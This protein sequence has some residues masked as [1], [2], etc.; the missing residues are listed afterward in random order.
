[1]GCLRLSF[2]VIVLAVGAGLYFRSTE[3]ARVK[4]ILNTVL[5]LTPKPIVDLFQSARDDSHNAKKQEKVTDNEVKSTNRIFSKQDLWDN[6]RGGDES[7]GLYLAFF[8]KVFDVSK[9]K[10]HY[11][12]GG[13]YHFFAGRDGTKGFVTG[14]FSDEGLTDDIE[15]MDSKLMIGF[16]DWI[17]FYSSSYTYV[18]TVIGQFYDENGEPTEALKN[19]NKLIA[20]A[21][22]AKKQEDEENK[23]LPMC[24][25]ESSAAKGSR[26]WC[27]TKSGGVER[28]WVGVPRQYHPPGATSP[29]CACVRTAGKP[30]YGTDDG[31]NRGD[32]DN[33]YLREYNG[34]HSTSDSCV[35]KQ[36]K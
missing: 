7:K 35:I 15:G 8:G 10:E 36:P 29:R 5:K 28:N 12:P 31:K 23:I 26:V 30:S 33:P 4:E 3:D 20:E 32:L 22:Q 34:C 21:K 27:S 1:M 19:A 11:G 14:D 9:G 18:G 2:I 6:Y 16:D 17:Q 13:G 24:N 25:S